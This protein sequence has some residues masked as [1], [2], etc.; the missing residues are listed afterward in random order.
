[1]LD[2]KMEQTAHL[3]ADERGIVGT[4]I[5]MVRTDAKNL[6]D[7]ERLLRHYAPD[8]FV[9]RGGAHVALHLKSGDF[10]RI[11]LVTEA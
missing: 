1:M 7:A 4:A 11:L 8:W 5:D 2:V 9:Y 6:P 10:R 3:N